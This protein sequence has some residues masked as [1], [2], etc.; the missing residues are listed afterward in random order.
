MLRDF[1]AIGAGGAL[2]AALRYVL[3]I[4]TLSVL[5]QAFLFGAAPANVLGA[6]A[7]GWLAASQLPS[8]WRPFLLTG[9]CGGFTTFSLFSLELLVL[10]ESG[11]VALAVAYGL[12]SVAVW[13][14]A[15]W[16]GF[17]L[18]GRAKRADNA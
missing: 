13:I 2:G 11:R 17:R 6:L 15:V 18:G 7:I 9:F 10:L 3:S 14:A 1:L 5:D 12:G 8:A 4:A 16:I